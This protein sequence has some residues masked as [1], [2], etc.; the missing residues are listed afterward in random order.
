MKKIIGAIMIGLCVGGYYWWQEK[1]TIPRFQK[2]LYV[3]A[4]RAERDV[5]L[6]Q[7]QV[8]SLYRKINAGV[9]LTAEETQLL[10]YLIND[11]QADHYHTIQ[12][13][14]GDLVDKVQSVPFDFIWGQAMMRTDN[15]HRNRQ[16]PF[17][18]YT[19]D[20]GKYKVQN[21]SDLYQ[22][23]RAFVKD[24]NTLPAFQ[25]FR[26]GRQHLQDG[27]ITDMRF[28]GQLLPQNTADERDYLQTLKSFLQGNK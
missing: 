8:Q 12:S 13:Q 10:R 5:R 17:G 15:G 21:F 28:L 2:A 27:Q 1:V 16:S 9:S 24:I 20:N 4:K 22:A 14:I 23:V 18:T 11:Y 25:H 3:A 7:A 6:Q 26:S 19:W